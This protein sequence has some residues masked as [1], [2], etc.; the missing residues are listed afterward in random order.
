MSTFTT[1]EVEQL[2]NPKGCT[3]TKSG[4]EPKPQVNDEM[5]TNLTAQMNGSVRIK[6][7]WFDAANPEHRKLVTSRDQRHRS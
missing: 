5:L 1:T 3:A 2:D 6:G 4:E 7:Q